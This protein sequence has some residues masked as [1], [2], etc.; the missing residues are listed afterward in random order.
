MRRFV[1][2]ILALLASSFAFGYEVQVAGIV[3]DENLD[4]L[5]GAKVLIQ[6]RPNDAFHYEMTV[7]TN[8]QGIFEETIDVGDVQVGHLLF[9]IETCFGNTSTTRATFNRNKTEVKVRLLQC[10]EDRDCGVRIVARYTGSGEVVLVAEGKGVGDLEYEWDNGETGKEIVVTEMGE[11]CVIMTDAEGCV[12]DDCIE[13]ERDGCEVEIRAVNTD[14]ASLDQVIVLSAKAKGRNPIKYLW[15]TD[16]TTKNIRVVEPGQYCV[17][18][19]DAT[20]CTAEDCIEIDP[21]RDCRTEIK[22]VR[23]NAN[24]DALFSVKLIARTKG[25]APFKYKWNNETEDTTQMI[26][27]TTPGE[28]CVVVV[29]ANGCESRDC[30]TIDPR[31]HCKTK[32]QVH[33]AA[34]SSVSDFR[35]TL[36]ARSAGIGPF[37]YQWNNGET[38]QSIHVSE[39]IE[40]CVEVTDAGGCVS[41]DCIDLSRL[42]DA[43]HVKIKSTPSGVLIAQPFGVP[44]FKYEWSN[45]D[46]TKVI[47]VDEPGNY[48]VTITD[49]FGCVADACYETDTPSPN[50]CYVRIGRKRVDQGLVE[51]VAVPKGLGDF[52]FEWSNG[53]ATESIL[54]DQEGEYCVVVSNNTCKA[55]LCV[56]VTFNN[57]GNANISVSGDALNPNGKPTGPKNNVKAD[58]FPNPF[59]SD[60]R[61]NIDLEQSGKV[62]V[63]I[64]RMDGSVVSR[65]SMSLDA[66]SNAR[67]LNLSD[68]REGT[69]Y[70]N[71]I[72]DHFVKTIRILKYD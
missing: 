33:R 3:L 46:I 59:V 48:C 23:P 47:K 54:V 61:L 29:D 10:R 35:L 65:Q 52:A 13:L 1:P 32:I 36:T 37:T 2:F 64:H 14:A 53:E 4:G 66:G 57:G 56:N 25:R 5:A 7:E 16:D 41:R 31:D 67:D 55:E 24:S 45:G 40:Y 68:L 27:V 60:L 44:P 15:S 19:T 63:M 6:T 22:V 34:N 39:L 12:A 51:L 11:Y 9:T 28:Y 62:Q 50:D 49:A 38:T 17:T 43:C 8:D 42:V 18:I 71:I 21:Q 20:G 70:V 58:A 72:G 26:R 69:Y 30:V